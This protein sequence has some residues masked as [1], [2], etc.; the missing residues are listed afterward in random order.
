[1]LKII[2]AA[3]E[4]PFAKKILIFIL[5]IAILILPIISSPYFLNLLITTLFWIYLAQC[6]NIMSGYAGQFS[7]GHAT[8]FGLGAYVSAMLFTEV[9]LT[10]WIGMIIGGFIA[11]I[12]GLFIGFLAFRYKLK[13]HYFALATLAFAEVLR[14]IFINW[15]FV[16]ASLGI[17]L[18]IG[19]KA[20][21]FQFSDPI[22][23]YYIILIMA[24]IIT[25][26]VYKISKIKLGLYLTAIREDEDAASALGVNAYKYKLIAVAISAF[27]TAFGGS[28]YVQFY[29]YIDPELAFS[30][31]ISINILTP[32][33]IGGVGTVFGPVVGG[34]LVTP[35]SE[36][37]RGLLPGLNMIVY[38]VIL[39]AVIIFVPDGIL[40]LLKKLRTKLVFILRRKVG[41]IN[42]INTESEKSN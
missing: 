22:Y 13:G 12:M 20:S 27:L 30:S 16:K 6:W 19:D 31:S 14:V 26:I 40:G 11:S 1:M 4:N 28:F 36:F 15:R 24:V 5:I 23:F 17:L 42:G 35:V 32:A 37:T 9:G 38:G 34:L 39:V 21:N 7:F 3:S 29:S 10:P 25:L 8:F 2:S 41:T 18:P 33:I